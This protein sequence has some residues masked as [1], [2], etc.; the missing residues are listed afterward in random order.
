MAKLTQE[1]DMKIFEWGPLPEKTMERSKIFHEN[2][3]Y[4]FHS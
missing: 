3:T 4:W 2:V 1:E